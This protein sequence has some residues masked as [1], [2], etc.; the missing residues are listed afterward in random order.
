VHR[1]HRPIRRTREKRRR[2]RTVLSHIRPGVRHIFLTGPRSYAI[3]RFPQNRGEKL[4]ATKNVP[5][6]IYEGQHIPIRAQ[7]SALWMVSR[8]SRCMVLRLDSNHR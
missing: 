2:S 1:W 4:L 3:V 7:R 8:P 5:L 6:V